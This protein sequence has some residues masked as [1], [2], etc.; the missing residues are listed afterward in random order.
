MKYEPQDAAESSLQLHGRE[1]EPGKSLNVYISDPGRK[2]ERTDADAN[3]RELYVAGLSK[4]TTKKD[5][6]Q[7]FGTVGVDVSFRRHLWY[8]PACVLLVWPGQGSEDGARLGREV[9]GIRLCGVC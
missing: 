6:E 5:L 7:I 8:S 1:L 2:K 9:Q 4:Y 3:D